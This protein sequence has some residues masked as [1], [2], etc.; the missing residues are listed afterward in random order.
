[1]PAKNDEVIV[2]KR[3]FKTV[4]LIGIVLNDDDEEEEE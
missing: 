3:I 2:Q 4:Y 1:M